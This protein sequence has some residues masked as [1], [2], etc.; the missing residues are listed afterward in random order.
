MQISE[1]GKAFIKRRES[2][3]LAPHWDAIGG[4]YDIGYGHVLTDDERRTYTA[5]GFSQTDADALFDVDSL[6]YGDHV[7]QLVTAPLLQQ[8]FDALTSFVYNI[9]H[10]S[11]ARSTLLQ[12]VNAEMHEA[13]C[14][15]L[16]TWNRARGNFVPGLL[17]RRA[18]EALMY[19]R[20]EYL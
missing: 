10:A 9:G 19:G 5:N 11:L 16:L 15:E 17:N 2:V 4:V 18:M 7:A 6:Y 14:L 8:M 1:D 20:G 3:V 13:A 12:Y